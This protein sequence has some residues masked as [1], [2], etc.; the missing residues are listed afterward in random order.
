[1][2]R[3]QK[4]A[5]FLTI[6]LL[7]LLQLPM[8]ML[9]QK[10]S[11]G[12]LLAVFLILLIGVSLY[13]GAVLGLLLSLIY[14]FIIGTF[15]F[16][17]QLTQQDVLSSPLD[18]QLNE[19]FIY[20]IAIL[21]LVLIAGRIRELVIESANQI[22]MLKGNVEKY[23][24]TDTTSGFDNR[25]RLEKAIVEEAKRSDRSDKPFVFLIIEIQNFKKFKK[26]YGEKEA[27][28]L[29]SQLAERI[30]GVM[31]MTDRKYRFDEDNFALIL[32]ETSGTYIHIIYEKLSE[33]L[34]EHQLLSG[35]LITLSFKV[36]HYT[37]NPRTE[38][39]FD[40]MVEVAKSE[41]LINEI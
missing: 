34:K 8:Y 20:G 17:L 6:V 9:Y 33:K 24:A 15:I 11:Q 29:V 36:G 7:I 32:P 27:Q 19:F 31:R 25:V 21:I 22:N 41:S 40:E 28:Y 12:I 37:Y 10:E 16:Y 14:L 30:N 35:N 4:T 1:M 5:S 26:L 39:S 13:Y 2:T 38:V 3:H 23:V 18:L